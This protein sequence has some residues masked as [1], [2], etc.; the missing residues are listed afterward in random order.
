MVSHQVNS[1]ESGIV[2]TNTTTSIGAVTN[3][4]IRE[5][6]IVTMLV[7]TIITSLASDSPSVSRSYDKTE[8]M[9]PA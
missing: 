7:S 1:A 9:S 3:I 2:T 4:I 5:P 8:I 6:T